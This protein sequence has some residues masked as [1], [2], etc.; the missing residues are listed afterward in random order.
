MDSQLIIS[1][2]NVK[3]LCGSKIELLSPAKINL[4]LNIV[5][6]YPDG[7]HKIE[8]IAERI[9]LFDKISI[10]AKKN[11]SVEIRC[12]LKKLENKKNLCYRAAQMM[13]KEFKITSKHQDQ[14]ELKDSYQ[15]DQKRP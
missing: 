11:P 8:S 15:K 10:K 9:S 5:G 14:F 1:Q 6:R 3:N 2:K 13:R 7:Y 4:Y 12:N